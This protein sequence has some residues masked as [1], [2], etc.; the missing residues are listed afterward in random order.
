MGAIFKEQ[1]V[2]TLLIPQEP[3]NLNI[4][5]DIFRKLAHSSIMKL[6][7]SSMEKLLYLIIMTVKK[8]VFLTSSPLEL[9]ALTVGNLR[10]LHHHSR[11]AA[12]EGL[13]KNAIEAFSSAA[14][15]YSYIQYLEIRDYLLTSL[16]SYQTKV[17]NFH[18]AGQQND[19]GKLTFIRR[20]AHNR[21]PVGATR[22]HPPLKI[23]Q[24][25]HPSN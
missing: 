17:I 11:G 12:S 5:K 8:E 1:F 25:N 22:N 13:V 10:M 2:K 24:T 16:E 3:I 9:F 18:E 20:N 7:S 15:S 21:M 14:A 6:D 4:L 23:S 19:Q